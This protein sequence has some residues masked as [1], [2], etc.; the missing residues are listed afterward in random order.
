MYAVRVIIILY[1]YIRHA[2][3]TPSFPG[4]T[5]AQALL[6][7]LWSCPKYQRKQSMFTYQPI[8]LSVV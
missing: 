4:H 8:S 1:S 5:E 7:I 6:M 3:S 2:L